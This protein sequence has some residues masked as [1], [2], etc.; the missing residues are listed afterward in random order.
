LLHGFKRPELLELHALESASC[1]T[2][3][4]VIDTRPRE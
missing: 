3:R 1:T 2:A 4:I